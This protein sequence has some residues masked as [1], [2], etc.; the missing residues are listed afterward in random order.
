MG[1]FKQG[2][3]FGGRYVLTQK[4][5]LGGFSE[6]WKAEDQ[7][8]EG[9]V[10]AVKIYAPEKGL[11]DPGLKQFRREY[12]LTQPLNHPNLLKASY[13]DIADGSPF[14]VMQYCSQGSLNARLMEQGTIAEN[15][16]ARITFQI[17]GALAYLHNK[18]ILHQDIKPDN[19]LIDDDGNFLLTD[20]GISS[21]LRSTLRKA[22]TS[23]G[24]LTVAYAP[25][26]RFDQMPRNTEAS[27]VFS[28]G[29]MLYELCDGD[30]PWMGSGG[31]TLL[32]GSKVPMVSE[33]YSEGLRKIIKACMVRD[34]SLR[35]TP[36]QLADSARQYLAT[37]NWDTSFVKEEPVQDG[38]EPAFATGRKTEML[39]DVE[40]PQQPDPAPMP[41]AGGVAPPP[42]SVPSDVNATRAD[43]SAS[44]TPKKKSKL[45]LV[46]ALIA[47]LVLGGGGF[48][49]YCYMQQAELQAKFDEAYNKGKKLA[50]EEKLAEARLAYEE[51]LGFIPDEPNVTKS[52]ADLQDKL[53]KKFDEFYEK[54]NTHFAK[55]EYK[56]AVAPFETALTYIP[57]DDSASKYLSL[58]KYFMAID[59]GD[60]F[61]GSKDFESARKYYEQALTLQPGDE[62]AQNKF[63]EAD[64]QEKAIKLAVVNE[65]LLEAVK[66]SDL[67]ATKSALGEGADPNAHDK[68]NTP[69]ILWAVKS[70][71]L[72]LVKE[73]VGKGAKCD[74][75]S[76][77]IWNGGA[78]IGHPAVA[79]AAYGHLDILKYFVESCNVKPNDQEYDAST[80]K[81]NGWSPLGAAANYGKLSEVKYM[82]S[83]GADVNIQQGGNKETPLIQACAAGHYDVVKYLLDNKAN[84]NLVTAKGKDAYEVSKSSNIKKLL[85][86]YGMA[87]FNYVDDF[88]SYANSIFFKDHAYAYDD[89]TKYAYIKNGK[90]TIRLNDDVG[91]SFYEVFDELDL[92]EDWTVEAKLTKDAGND[93][94]GLI[95][96]GV[97]NDDSYRVL[98]D[99]EDGE[100][101]VKRLVNNQWRTVIDYTYSSALKKGSGTNVVKVE[102]TGDYISVYINGT[103][104]LNRERLTSFPGRAFGIYIQTVR[105]QV[106]AEYFK[107]SG[108]R[109]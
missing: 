93:R 22:T 91:Y 32:S 100:F 9:T 38:N 90:M 101:A 11:D 80:K 79:A 25:P 92:T 78:S 83:K 54:G 4:L 71:Q 75:K 12:A 3:V 89:Q 5:G 59:S 36:E 65:K 51:A 87:K 72:D 68:G 15:D 60:V 109:R 40:T 30:V 47:I 86:D 24:A 2:D 33:K 77:V 13:F 17:G 6:V 42:H 58:S 69:A 62:V 76:G 45:G 107:L 57:D 102:K 99:P 94:Y 55:Q 26:E 63:D 64:R 106:T 96:A 73:L 1:N 50:D 104:V 67:A 31:I 19:I 61:M 43:F 48:F 81:N 95:F 56:S 97:N 16:I 34:M 70:G 7:M 98:L 46:I 49:A 20:F 66:N 27:D 82:V 52:L 39:S 21:R 37:G 35:P 14:L 88:D 23:S 44:E 29:V 8:T 41:N 108:S 103:K 18:G 84:Y 74:D 10:V 105:N 85:R 28:F 53:Q